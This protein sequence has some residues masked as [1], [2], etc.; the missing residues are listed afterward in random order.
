MTHP[1]A[2]PGGDEGT[3]RGDGAPLIADPLCLDLLD[4]LGGD[5]LLDPG[6]DLAAWLDALAWADVLLNLL[7]AAR[8]HSGPGAPNVVGVDDHDGPRPGGARP[9]PPGQGDG[10]SP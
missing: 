8:P 2:P 4:C 1:S 7:L 3:L 9:S 6:A 10:G 5:D